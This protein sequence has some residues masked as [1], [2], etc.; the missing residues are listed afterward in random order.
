MPP[1]CWPCVAQ[2][3][4]AAPEAIF[5][6][7]ICNAMAALGFSTP[8]IQWVAGKLIGCSLLLFHATT[9]SDFLLGVGVSSA[10]IPPILDYLQWVRGAGD[11]AF[12]SCWA[13]HPAFSVVVGATPTICRCLL[14]LMDPLA[15]TRSP[16][17][18]AAFHPV[19]GS[20]P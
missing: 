2:D 3:A 14:P 20:S 16:S 9:T 5:G 15:W 19:V 4:A 1:V 12:L 7:A 6:A 13:G 10:Y 11:A 18:G 8:M 17:R